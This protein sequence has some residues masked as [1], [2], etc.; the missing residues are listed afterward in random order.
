MGIGPCQGKASRPEPS[1]G[2]AERHLSDGPKPSRSSRRPFRRLQNRISR[3]LFLFQMLLWKA[4][5]CGA[6]VQREF[7][8][9]YPVPFLIPEP[10]RSRYR[11]LTAMNEALFARAE[12]LGWAPDPEWEPPC[13]VS[14]PAPRGMRSD[15]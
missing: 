13:V 2:V 11:F 1:T 8:S 15:R 3:V 5:A 12:A 9:N 7:A 6:M 14:H 10:A 4:T